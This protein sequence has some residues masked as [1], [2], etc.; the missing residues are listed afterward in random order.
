[1]RTWVVSG[2]GHLCPKRNF[3]KEGMSLI[4]KR[5]NRDAALANYAYDVSG[6][7]APRWRDGKL[8]GAQFQ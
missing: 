3:L 4:R 8:W 6:P 1:M 5:E 7:L 2:R